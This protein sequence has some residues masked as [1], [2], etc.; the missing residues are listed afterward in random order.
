[1]K[2][3][4]TA[5]A[6]AVL[7]TAAWGAPSAM[8]GGK[9]HLLG[10]YKVEKHIDLEG[11]EGTYTLSCNGTDIAVDG[12]WRIDNVDQDNDWVDP[13]TPTGNPANDVLLSV[14][15]VAAYPTSNSTY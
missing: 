9:S 2:R 4:I 13:Y 7:V 15:A 5:I 14:Q 1:M 8:A 12:M 6:A 3:T 10:N 11:E